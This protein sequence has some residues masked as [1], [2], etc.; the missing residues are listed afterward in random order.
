MTVELNGTI[1]E[2]VSKDP[3]VVKNLSTTI[4]QA[5]SQDPNPASQSDWEQR[6]SLWL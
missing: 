4:Q 2:P 6:P 3:L 5:A 1:A